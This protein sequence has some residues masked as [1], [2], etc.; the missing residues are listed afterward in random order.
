EAT[1]SSDS[2]RAAATVAGVHHSTLQA[3]VIEWNA[4]LGFDLRSPAGR[5]RLALALRLYRLATFELPS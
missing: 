2:L 3:H 4:A 5:V 1:A